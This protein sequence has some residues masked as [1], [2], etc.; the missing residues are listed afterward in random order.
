MGSEKCEIPVNMVA[1]VMGQV[2]NCVECWVP[3]DVCPVPHV[4]AVAAASSICDTVIDI[5]YSLCAVGLGHV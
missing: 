5:Y 4:M 3:N 2:M 1:M